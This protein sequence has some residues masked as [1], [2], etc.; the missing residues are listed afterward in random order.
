MRISIWLNVFNICELNTA[1]QTFSTNSYRFQTQALRE[2]N[3]YLELSSPVAADSHDLTKSGDVAGP[4]E[5][6]T[7][8]AEA[9]AVSGL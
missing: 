4:D 6:E 5:H 2:N 9:M 1:L 8:E 7:T 3:S